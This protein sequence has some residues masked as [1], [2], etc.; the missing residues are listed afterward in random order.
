[1]MFSSGTLEGATSGTAACATT[2]AFRAATGLFLGITAALAGP[3]AE[4]LASLLLL[5]LVLPAANAIFRRCQA[6][7]RFQRMNRTVGL[8]VVA[9][10]RLRIG[11][12]SLATVGVVSIILT[13]FKQGNSWRTK[14]SPSFNSYVS[15]CTIHTRSSSSACPLL[16]PT[17]CHPPLSIRVT[18]A[19][20]QP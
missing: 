4:N 17:I 16:A 7:Y 10:I 5:L 14:T 2:D 11:P 1:M 20:C 18:H 3:A 13:K 6:L 9:R 19:R 12:S 8:R 15:S